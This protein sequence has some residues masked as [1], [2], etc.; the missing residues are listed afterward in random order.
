MEPQLS[1]EQIDE[2]FAFTSKKY[3]KYYDV[4]V[5]LVDHIANKIEDMQKADPDLSFDR[6]LYKVYK[7]FG[8]YGFTKVQSQ[9]TYE[10]LSYWSKRMRYHFYQYFKPPQILLTIGL[11]VVLFFLL[12]SL[13]DLF[14]DGLVI[15]GGIFLLGAAVGTLTY[16][17]R[18]KRRKIYP[19]KELLVLSTYE[20]A[21]IN[22]SFFGNMFIPFWVNLPDLTNNSV[23]IIGIAIVAVIFAFLIISIHASI[24]VFPGWLHEELEEK[25]QWLDLDFRF[26][27]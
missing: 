15:S 11:S 12:Q 4:Q 23:H 8:V 7:S 19:E 21:L 17:K 10:L 26:T 24:F 25:Y 9:K 16:I 18:R 27:N 13:C 2:I 14:L 5:E 3:I 22:T 1:K 20:G 6:A